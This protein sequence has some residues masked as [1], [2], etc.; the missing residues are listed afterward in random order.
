MVNVIMLTDAYGLKAG[1]YS[2]FSQ[3][4]FARL[5]SMNVCKELTQEIEI[6]AGKETAKTKTKV[7]SK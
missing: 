5:A 4:D 2:Q 1:Q 6:K 3:E 7:K